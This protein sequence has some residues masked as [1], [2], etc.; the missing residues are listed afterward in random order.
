MTQPSDTAKI[1]PMPTRAKKFFAVLIVNDIVSSRG[2]EY[3]NGSD[4]TK[5]AKSFVNWVRTVQAIAESE[6][7]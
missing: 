4:M 7:D 3:A 1:P 5:D 6:E 2:W